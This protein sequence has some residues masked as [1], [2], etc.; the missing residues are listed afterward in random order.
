MVVILAVARL[1]RVGEYVDPVVETSDSQAESSV[2]EFALRWMTS[3]PVVF[4]RDHGAVD[5]ASRSGLRSEKSLDSLEASS[6]VLRPAG[7][8]RQALPLV[9]GAS[10]ARFSQDRHQPLESADLKAHNR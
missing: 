5:C 9:V 1:R 7:S 6:R 2:D 4:L 3:V 8:S 10:S